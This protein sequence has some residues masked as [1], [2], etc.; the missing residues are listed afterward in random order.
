MGGRRVVAHATTRAFSSSV[1]IVE[2]IGMQNHFENDTFR[3]GW[4]RGDQLRKALIAIPVVL[5]AGCSGNLEGSDSG[6]SDQVLADERGAL[7]VTRSQ[8]PAYSSP[9]VLAHGDATLWAV[10]PD[11]DRVTVIDANTSTVLATT[12]VGKNPQSVAVDPANHYAYVANFGSNDV[13]VIDV[14]RL[15]SRGFG[16][17]EQDRR[18][19]TGAAPASVVVSPDGRRVFVANSGQDTITVLSGRDQSPVGVIDLRDS[20]CNADDHSRH[21]QPRG[22]A[23][24]GDGR[25]LFVTRFLSYTRPGGAQRADYGK[26]GLVCRLDLEPDSAGFRY[27]ATPIRLAPTDTGFVDRN[28]GATGAFPNQMQSIVLRDGH[29]YLPNIAAS[30]SGP[31]RFDVDTQAYVN[32]ID[33]IN[34][35]ARDGGALN[36]HLGARD[37]EPGKQEL[38]FAN[39]WAMA[40]ASGSGRGT[41]YVVSAASDLL[42]KLNVDVAGA[43]HFTG[44]A[45][46]TRYID[47]NDP[48][49]PETSGINAGKNPIGIVINGRGTR[50]YVLNYVSRNLS[51]V[52]LS[53][54]RVAAVVSIDRLPAPGSQSEELLVGAELFFSSRG[55]FVRPAGADGS[56][57][58]RLSEKGHQACSSC[59]AAGLTDGVVWQFASGPR[60]TIAI[61][62][63]TNPRDRSQ[64]RIINASAIFDEL[65]DVDF[66]TRRVSSGEPLSVPR[67]C[68]DSTSSGL[69]LSTNDPEHGLILGA[70]DDLSRAPCVLV[71]F[72][73][74]NENRP[75]LRVQLP[76]SS[77]Q[78]GAT[79]ALKE[80]QRN[81]IATPNRPL[82]NWELA[83]A[84]LSGTGGDVYRMVRGRELF[85]GAGCPTCHGGAQ[86]TTKIK[87]FVSPPAAAEIATEMAP[88]AN[89]TQYLFRFL[90][91]VGTFDLNVAGAT[92]LLPGYPPIGGVETDT[93]G[94]SA[95]GFDYDGDGKGNGYN[96]PSL[97]GGFAAPPYFH[98]GACE[99]F[100]C[101]LANTR[102]R[103]AGQRPGEADPLDDERAREMLA[104]YL[105]SI[106]LRTA[107]L[108]GD[109]RRQPSSN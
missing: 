99:T 63:T 23:I 9:I 88:G 34:G 19:V 47:L 76:G 39:P 38:Y 95:L 102:H 49:A 68:V 40:F 58:N 55:N 36:L 108:R 56:T 12:S 66:N 35:E 87:D 8:G 43:L 41:A 80:W 14:D 6:G 17:G 100:Q 78:I 71:P 2:V 4:P 64:Q 29:A 5:L 3:W 18:I 79:D 33:D 30:P 62:G 21:F 22:M 37:P 53:R 25:R 44:D 98:N 83:L 89:A 75:Q 103:R 85:E 1:P 54:D 91:D 106:D 69:S 57:R 101:V 73:V 46:T 70:E 86:W 28:G 93:N 90:T 65:E 77:V 50:A 26:E 27:H 20:A 16:G 45:D 109:E 92:N 61:N 10:S 32:R 7:L 67:P 107:P 48:D 74:P 13:S 11:T 24:T 51:V 59:H 81:A 97:L 15:G 105:E 84:G 60:K 94:L 52:D 31:L 96:T 72:A 82:N 104:L 42:V